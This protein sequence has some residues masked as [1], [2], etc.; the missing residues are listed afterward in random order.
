[1]AYAPAAAVRGKAQGPAR[2]APDFAFE[3][4]TI[5]SS[6]P[7]G[8]S[9]TIAAGGPFKKRNRLRAKKISSDS[10]VSRH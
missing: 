4:A 1:M 5:A 10:V 9:G 2:D 7:W 3:I 8:R 6:P